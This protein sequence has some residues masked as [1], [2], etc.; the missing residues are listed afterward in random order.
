MSKCSLANFLSFCGLRYEP[1]VEFGQFTVDFFLSEL[2]LVLEAD[3]IY[4]HLRKAD[5]KRDSIL[6]QHSEIKDVR[7]LKGQTNQELQK[8]I[9]NILVE[10]SCQE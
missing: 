1:Q 9:M 7:H 2:S 5:R 8:E 3:G 4:G 6:L 10:F